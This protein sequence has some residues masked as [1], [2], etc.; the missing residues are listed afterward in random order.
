MSGR[1]EGGKAI[2]SNERLMYIYYPGDDKKG[3]VLLST[4]HPVLRFP[5]SLVL[6]IFLNKF[7][8]YTL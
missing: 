3:T 6:I 4:F 7:A 5:N 1:G 2:I 8:R